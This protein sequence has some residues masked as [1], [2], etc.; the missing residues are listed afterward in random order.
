MGLFLFM[1]YFTDSIGNTASDN[2]MFVKQLILNNL[3]ESG[4]GLIEVLSRNLPG[5]T[6][7]I[8]EKFQ[9]V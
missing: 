9:P 3:E 7:E 6:E 4:L 5:G 1:G 8:H 2:R